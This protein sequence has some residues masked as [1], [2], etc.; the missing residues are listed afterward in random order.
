MIKVLTFTGSSTLGFE[1]AYLIANGRLNRFAEVADLPGELIV[2][3]ATQSHVLHIPGLAISY[4]VQHTITLRV[5]EDYEGWIAALP[6]I[7]SVNPRGV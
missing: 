2:Q 7:E 3:Q 4:M 6:L 5:T 1:D